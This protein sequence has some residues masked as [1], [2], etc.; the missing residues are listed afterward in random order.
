[1]ENTA[2]DNAFRMRSAHGPRDQQACWNSSPVSDLLVVRLLRCTSRAARQIFLNLQLRSILLSRDQMSP[3][4]E[5]AQP[6]MVQVARANWLRNSSASASGLSIFRASRCL[7]RALR[8]CGPEPTRMWRKG[9]S[10]GET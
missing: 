10:L 7:M 6:W 5:L 2:S 3:A 8:V 9:L 4:K 1:M